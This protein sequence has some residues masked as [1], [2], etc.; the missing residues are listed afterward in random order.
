MV[1]A[2]LLPQFIIQ[3]DELDD[4][5]NQLTQL[6]AD[7]QNKQ[8]NYQKLQDQLNNIKSRVVFLQQQIVKK[9]QEVALGEKT[10]DYQKKLLNERAKS[11]YK[12]ISK[13]A[14]SFLTL[15]VA[16]DLSTSLQNFFYQKTVVDQDRDTII[17]IVL[18]IKNLEEKKAQLAREKTGL[19]AVQEEIDK[20]SQVLAGDIAATQSKIVELTARQQQILAQRL[21]ALNIPRSAYTSLSGC[22]D[23]RDK[24]PGFSP[25]F[26]LFT[27]GVPNRVGLNQYGAKG[28][29]EAGENNEENILRAYYNFD[30][31]GTVDSNTQ[32]RVDGYDT[33]SLED[34]LKGI[35]EMPASFPPAALRAQAIASRSYVMAYTNSGSGTI[36]A[37]ESCQVFSPPGDRNDAWT[38]AVSDTRGKVML[39]GGT[40]IK[41]WFSSTHGGYILSSGEIGWSATNWTKHAIDTTTGGAGS[42]GDLQ[43][44]AYDRSSPWFYCDW[45]SR[46]N[47]N[48][49]AWLTSGEIAD[50]ANSLMLVKSDS[51]T[52]EHLYQTDKSNPAGTDNWDDSRV[53]QEL[54]NRGQTPFTNVSSVSVNAD[55]GSG[56]TTSITVSGNTSQ[57]FSGDEW[58]NRFNLRAPANIQ[59]VGP[60]FNVEIK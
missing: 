27:Y 3:A 41:A 22:V 48:N 36:C 15:L 29:A 44:N 2:F 59:I 52:T 7:L 4:I 24:D 47:Y 25:R 53:R 40:P 10:L 11:Y 37:S 5:N 30:S 49:T 33:Y 46:G 58:K 39:Q 38:Q 55:F 28:R 31:V 51:S 43:N 50:I 54:Q 34:Y 13:N 45:G 18:Y 35:H 6:R 32:I 56:K 60:L 9:E 42:F 1:A 21:A 17:K 26:A 57:N 23:D 16:S 19:A 20:Q 12:N 14:D 8:T